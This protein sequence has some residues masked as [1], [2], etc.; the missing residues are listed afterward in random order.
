MG[1]NVRMCPSD[2]FYVQIWLHNMSEYRHIIFE[3]INN[4]NSYFVHF[5]VDTWHQ[6]YA[7]TNILLCLSLQSSVFILY[8]TDFPR[9]EDGHQVGGS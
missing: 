6:K 5:H 2:D 9:G 3:S 4:R 1:V 8:K 7:V